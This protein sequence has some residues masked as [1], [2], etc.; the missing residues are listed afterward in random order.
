MTQMGANTGCF[1]GDSHVRLHSKLPIGRVAPR[2]T[3]HIFEGWRE[4]V[5]APKNKP[6]WMPDKIWKPNVRKIGIET[7]DT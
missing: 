3:V 6:D 4:Q 5:N 2:A 7:H 1:P